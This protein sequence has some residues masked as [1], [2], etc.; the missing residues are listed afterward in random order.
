M[1]LHVVSY[2]KYRTDRDHVDS[3]EPEE[4]LR[5]EEN[6]WEKNEENSF[7]KKFYRKS[8]YSR[9]NVQFLTQEYG[10]GGSFINKL[11]YGLWI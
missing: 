8:S 2:S 9:A 3:T 10:V 4:T 7:Q 11:T 6:H 1:M 5:G